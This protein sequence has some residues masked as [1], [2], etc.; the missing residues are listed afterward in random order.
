MH[1]EKYPFKALVVFELLSEGK[2]E[3]I[4]KNIRPR[5][6]STVSKNHITIPFLSISS[7]YWSMDSIWPAVVIAS[8]DNLFLFYYH[9][10]ILLSDKNKAWFLF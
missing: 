8:F 2:N 1:K 7:V 9:I 6:N 4:K 5:E 10:I 3:K